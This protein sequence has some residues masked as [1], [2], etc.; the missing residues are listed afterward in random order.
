[1]LIFSFPTFFAFG[2][3]EKKDGSYAGAGICQECHVEQTK[4]MS[5]TPHWKKAIKDSPVANRGCESCHGPGTTH[6]SEG[7]GTTKGLIT[8]GKKETAKQKSGAC[9]VC[10]QNSKE[11]TF[12][13]MGVHK[14]NDVTCVDCHTVHNSAVHN[15]KTTQPDLCLTCH[16]NM[17]SQLNRQAHHPIKE[18]KVKCTDCHT[19][20]GGF[21]PKM[22]RADSTPDLCYKCHAEK[23]GPF[24][25]EHPPV[26]ENCLTCHQPHGSNHENLLTSKSPRLCQSCHA[27]SGHNNRPY[28][29]QNRLGGKATSSQNRFVGQGCLNCHG[30]IHGSNRSPF[31]VR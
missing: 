3:A 24:A 10:H 27:T 8:F 2:A 26:A 7:G 21:G 29:F 31:F 19:P 17:R 1:M 13:D 18:G 9:L 30:N 14:Q 20:H 15:L 4:S 6:V 25:F 28:S 16:K 23:R 22:I 5:K 11:M 12:F